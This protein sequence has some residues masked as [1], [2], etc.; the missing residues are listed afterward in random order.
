[1]KMCLF[2]IFISLQ[3]REL[4]FHLINSFPTRSSQEGHQL[5][6]QQN[7]FPILFSTLIFWQLTL[8]LPD[9][10]HPQFPNTPPPSHPSSAHTW[11]TPNCCLSSSEN[12]SVFNTLMWKSYHVLPPK[13]S[14]TITLSDH[15]AK[16]FFDY[17]QK[18][19]FLALSLQYSTSYLGE[20]KPHLLTSLSRSNSP[21]NPKA[22]FLIA[23]LQPVLHMHYCT[24]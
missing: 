7:S 13:G 14:G 12:S 8:H 22:Y 19:L 21:D 17:F 4:E 3:G 11:G 15:A 9:P 16:Q 23:L 24:M 6:N 20:N 2:K 18:I 1:M 10:N 5:R